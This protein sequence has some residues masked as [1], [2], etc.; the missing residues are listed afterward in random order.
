MMYGIHQVVFRH[1]VALEEFLPVPR[2]R[3]PQRGFGREA[4]C[5]DHSFEGDPIKQGDVSRSESFIRCENRG[6]ERP[7]G[8]KGRRVRKPR[9][10]LGQLDTRFGYVDGGPYQAVVRPQSGYC[11]RPTGR[12][13]VVREVDSVQAGGV[14]RGTVVE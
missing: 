9:G 6:P 3:G 4:V 12:A 13:G 5:Q 11:D 14:V 8:I 2:S 10:G 7:V 1:Q